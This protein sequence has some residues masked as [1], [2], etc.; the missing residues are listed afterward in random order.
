M[1][2]KP[3]RDTYPNV[4]WETMEGMDSLTITWKVICQ[5][6]APKDLAAS[7]RLGFTSLKQPSSNLAIRG[8]P[9]MVMEKIAAVVP[10]VVPTTSL[11]R[12]MMVIM[13]IMKGTDRSTLIMALITSYISRLGRSPF[14]SVVIRTSASTKPRRVQVTTVPPSIISVSFNPGRIMRLRM[15][16]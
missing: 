10:I 6:D 16:W 11:V 9:T 14:T 13:R 8:E 4:R 12:G 3:K 7:M 2:V 15:V 1:A 5:S